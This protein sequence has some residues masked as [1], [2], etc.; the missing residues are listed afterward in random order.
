MAI[1]ARVIVALALALT[2]ALILVASF[3]GS[4]LILWATIGIWGPNL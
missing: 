2:G 4:C 1:I 3:L